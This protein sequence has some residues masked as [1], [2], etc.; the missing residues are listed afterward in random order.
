VAERAALLLRGDHTLRVVSG[1]GHMVPLDA[2]SELV[3][4]VERALGR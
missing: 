2:P 3:D 1:V 4:A